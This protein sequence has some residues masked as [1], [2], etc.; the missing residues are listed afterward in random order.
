MLKIISYKH[1]LFAICK[2][3]V[4]FITRAS[5]KIVPLACTISFKSVVFNKTYVKDVAIGGVGFRMAGNRV[6][7]VV[8]TF[9]TW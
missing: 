1:S 9:A 8:A 6:Q 2:I 5:L 4:D 7:F 3:K